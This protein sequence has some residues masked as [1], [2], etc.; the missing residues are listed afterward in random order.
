[1]VKSGLHGL[2]NMLT[3]VNSGQYQSKKAVIGFR[4]V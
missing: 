4:V 1:M 3:L 2:R